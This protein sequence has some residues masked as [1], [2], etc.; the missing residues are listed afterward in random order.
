MDPLLI[1][2]LTNVFVATLCFCMLLGMM[3]NI[4]QRPRLQPLD[5]EIQTRKKRKS[6]L[7]ILKGISFINKPI[8]AGLLGRRMA[9]DLL[10]GRVDFAP[11]EFLLIK[12][13]LIAI[14]LFLVFPSIQSNPDMMFFWVVLAFVLGYMAPEYWLKGKI[15]KIK[16]AVIKELPDTIDLLSLCVNAGLDFM[17]A[18]KW[19]IEKS[20]K[21]ILIDELNLIMQEINVG[22][23]RRNALSDFSKKYDLPDV[24]T[25]ARTLIQADRMGTSVAEALNILSE[26]MRLSRF[27]RGEQIAL[28]APLKMLIPL[29]LFIFPV[30]GVLVGGPIFLEFMKG[31]PLKQVAGG[32]SGK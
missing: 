24:S 31:N 7:I 28:K 17:L 21:T 8:C 13:I 3:V 22:K 29:L 12:E 23:S 19:V 14:I 2:T 11:E 18:L 4:E 9:K 26:D 32:I 30:V 6:P 20:R 10:V 16:N 27:R 25:F 15:K 5:S 1:L